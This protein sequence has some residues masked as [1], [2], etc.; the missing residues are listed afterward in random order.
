MNDIAW[1]VAL[2]LSSVIM[3]VASLWALFRP[4]A[5][6]IARKVADDLKQN[7]KTNE[8]HDVGVQMEQLDDRIERLDVSIND[9]MDQQDTR[10]SARI[11]QL[12]RTVNDRM[13][14]LETRFNDRTDQMEGRLDKRID[15]LD[16]RLTGAIS[17]VRTDLGRM[18]ETQ[19]RILEAIRAISPVGNQG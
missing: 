3:G 18:H 2:A 6:G 17:E 16:A 1:S 11:D 4:M 9:R 13:D 19:G 14:R 12:D 10:V 5:T 7:L 8:F 15:Q